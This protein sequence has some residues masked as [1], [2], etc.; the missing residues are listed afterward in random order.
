VKRAIG[1]KEDREGQS[2]YFLGFPEEM[3][4]DEEPQ[5][6]FTPQ[7]DRLFVNGPSFEFEIC[8][9]KKKEMVKKEGA[10]CFYSVL[11]PV[12]HNCEYE[13]F[14]PKVH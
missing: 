9:L 13:V 1:V 8:Q 14:F 3:C 6:Y 11:A 10:T 7:A 12:K 5:R 2:L 4:F